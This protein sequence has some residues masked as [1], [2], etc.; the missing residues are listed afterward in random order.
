MKEILTSLELLKQQWGSA[1]I[2]QEHSQNQERSVQFEIKEQFSKML[3]FNVLVSNI[4]DH[5]TPD[6][7]RVKYKRS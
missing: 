7:S 4:L 1:V 6:L 5:G 2:L 3:L